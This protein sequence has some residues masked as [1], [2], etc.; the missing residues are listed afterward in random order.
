MNLKPVLKKSIHPDPIS[1][2]CF[3]RNRFA[4]SFWPATK[5]SFKFFFNWLH[6]IKLHPKFYNYLSAICCIFFVSGRGIYILYE[7]V[8]SCQ[9]EDV[10][11]LWSILVES[12]TPSLPS[13]HWSRIHEQ[14]KFPGN[15]E[16]STHVHK[17]LSCFIIFWKDFWFSSLLLEF[18]VIDLGYT[19]EHSFS[20]KFVFFF[21]FSLNFMQMVCTNSELKGNGWKKALFLFNLLCY[22]FSHQFPAVGC[23][24]LFLLFL[25]TWSWLAKTI[26]W[27]E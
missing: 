4:N 25:S 20:S 8:K 11:V 5:D 2:S 14:I 26:E 12:H 16:M 17:Y 27:M 13:K 18:L 19:S 7:D 23:S 6:F 1:F 10:H 21:F 24:S 15:W 22:F 3:Y 9:Y